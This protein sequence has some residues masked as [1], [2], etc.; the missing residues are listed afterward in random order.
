MAQQLIDPRVSKMKFDR[1]VNV[2]C[3]QA[4]D[5]RSRGWIIESIEYPVVRV[6]FLVTT[7]RPVIAPFT[8][9]VDFTNYNFLPLSLRFLDP[10]SFLPTSIDS[11]RLTENGPQKV[12]VHG[13]PETKEDFL[14]LPGVLQYHSH[15]QHSGDSWDLHRYSGK[16][17]LYSLLDYTWL[18]CVRTISGFQIPL[19]NIVVNG[20]YLAMGLINEQVQ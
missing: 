9:E 20:A 8:V 12:I 16:G 10:I 19:P 14:C 6:T 18:Y 7:I 3:K 2:L 4:S 15:P 5:L 13:H 17:K 1:E 11:I